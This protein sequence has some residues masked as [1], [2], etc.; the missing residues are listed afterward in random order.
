MISLNQLITRLNQRTEGYDQLE[1]LMTRLNQLMTTL[2]L[3]TPA[4]DQCEQLMTI[5]N[6]LTEANDQLKPGNDHLKPTN[7]QLEPAND[8][9]KPTIDHCEPTTILNHFTLTSLNK[10]MTISNQQMNQLITIVT[11]C[12]KQF[13]NR[14]ILICT[15]TLFPPLSF[16][17]DTEMH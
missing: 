4:N 2:N 16:S 3:L 12:P 13:S 8:H 7:D 15:K 14:D 6:Q 9:L 5:L 10:V 11:M 1:Q 17:S